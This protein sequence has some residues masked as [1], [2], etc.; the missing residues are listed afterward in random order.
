MLVGLSLEG[1]DRV[2]ADNLPI[3]VIRYDANGKRRYLNRAAERMLRADAAQL[4]GLAPC[5]GGVLSKETAAAFSAAID[6]VA[7]SGEARVVEVSLD[8]LPGAAE[9]ETYSVHFV[10][11]SCVDGSRA[12]LAAF[13]DITARF[14][15]EKALRDREAFLSSLLNTI[16]IPVFYKDRAGRYL[17]FNTAFETYFRT[18]KESQIGKSVFDTHPRH[19]AEIY[20]A[21]DEALFQAGGEQQ[22]ESK[23]TS[24][25]G[26]EREVVFNKAVFADRNGVPQ[27]LIGVVQDITERK[28]AERA[29]Q[30]HYEEVLSL[31]EQLEEGARALEEY[32]VELEAS[33]EQIKETEAWYR[34]IL[35]AAPDGIFVVNDEGII[36]L[37]NA[38]LSQMF[39][40]S[41]GELVGMPMEVL[42]PP[43]L[44]NSHSEKR[45]TFSA[46]AKE[47]GAAR[48]APN[49]RA[50][51]RDGS[52]FWVDVTLA[53]L[54]DSNAQTGTIC[55]AVRDVTEKREAEHRVNEAYARV[56]GMLH[57]I[58]DL[59]WMKDAEG[60]YLLCN[61]QFERLTGMR[62]AEIVGKTDYDLFDA[63]LAA[64]FLEKDRATIEAMQ[65]CVNE[66]LVTYPDSGQVAFLETRKVPVVGANGHIAGV[67][68]VAR[69]ITLRKQMESELL[70][71][72]QEFRTLAENAPDI[73][74]RYDRECRRIYVNPAFVNAVQL[75]KESLLGETPTQY[76][77]SLHARE[78]ESAIRKVLATGVACEHEY[79][80]V[81]SDGRLIISAFSI[82]PEKDGDGHVQSVLAVGRDIT[83]R[84]RLEEALELREREF[85]TLVENSRDTVVRYGR[86]LRRI[87]VNPAFA[88]LLNANRDD[89]VGK[90]PSEYPG[91]E[92]GALYEKYLVEVFERGAGFEVEFKWPAEDG[93]EVCTL[94]S[95]T[96]EL[97]PDGKVESILAFGRDITELHESRQKIHQMAF[98]DSLTALPNRALFNDRLHQM[99]TDAAW[100]GELAGV[101]LLDMDRFKE[102]NDTMGHAVGDEL[103]REA[104]RRIS[105]CV[106]SYDTVARLG[107]DEFAILLPEI[108]A[109]ED[110]GRIAS[111]ILSK[112]S[113][114]FC[115]DGKEVF[116]SCSIGIVLY[117]D[118]SAS[119]NDLVKYAD[120]AMYFAKRSGRNNFRFYSRD[121][122]ASANE[123][124]ALE[125]E[126]RRAVERQEL[127]L[128][129]QPKVSLVTGEILGS[130]ALLRWKNEKFGNVSPAQFIP[131]AEDTGL[132]AGIGEW[133]LRQ[134]CLSAAEWNA[135][136][137]SLHKVAIN[138][139]PR[140][141][142]TEDLVQS[143]SRIL[144]E[145]GCHPEW[146]ELEI[147]E[148]LLLD[149][150]GGTLETLA[151]FKSMGMTIAIDD[152]GTGYSA[153]SYLARFPI[154]TLKIDRSFVASVATDRYRAELVKAILSIA[155]C[156]KQEVVAEGVETLE[157]AEFLAAH[158]CQVAQGFLYSRPL[159]KSELVGLPSCFIHLLPEGPHD[160]SDVFL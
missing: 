5:D 106:R 40:Y 88:A 89:L 152:F 17:G 103:L 69:D 110:L 111:K 145:T 117:P 21:K 11:D 148:S 30:A 53:R 136:A 153:L 156:L 122:T 9:V 160:V 49:V 29:R 56:N 62:E 116:V 127:E 54:P 51:R 37:A 130:E 42:V 83:E 73:I 32:A 108:R 61:P 31:N 23:L 24:V 93:G 114:R 86:D 135:G 140:Q 75:P 77:N 82:V 27:G 59:I 58:P 112:F 92:N 133:V 118:D 70:W 20:F 87:Y 55:A 102:I 98:Y 80:F 132:I 44:R 66:E 35:Q 46:L 84:K 115:L 34:G 125:F 142:Q 41:A 8:A 128:H 50:C 150:D 101:M 121:L 120:S 129:Y 157:Q 85:R 138:L 97:G 151:A 65:A 154:D 18:T 81:T 15:A 38:Q 2:Y 137:K 16:P 74:M 147:T 100:H 149:E 134:A 139:S 12:V 105:S 43:G 19:L 79:P 143:L 45:Q 124:L 13:F 91:G 109:S 67:L 60:V 48:L 71:R 131:I 146:I 6:E 64:Y 1:Q 47:G 72:E 144:S 76:S 33:Q 78:Y 4:I 113:K 104:A 36:T 7:R 39:G 68:G 28:Q 141:F 155:R 90:T 22:Y 14:Q 96:P 95:F 107:G 26:E 158:G 57:A 94:T 119:P 10:A 52:E 159:P 25:T 123:R 126:L 3:P 63:N 99:I